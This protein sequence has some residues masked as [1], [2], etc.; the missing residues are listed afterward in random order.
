MADGGPVTVSG[1]YNAVTGSRIAGNVQPEVKA[2]LTLDGRSV[3]GGESIILTVPRASLAPKKAVD[4]L[5]DKPIEIELEGELLAM[6]GES[7]PF[8]VD[9]PETV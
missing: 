2:K 1:S 5:S 7:A 6:E 4:F 8:Y 9:R 3:I